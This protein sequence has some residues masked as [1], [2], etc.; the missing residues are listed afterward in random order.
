MTTFTLVRSALGPGWTPGVL[1][2]PRADGSFLTLA[3]LELPW[4]GNQRGVSCIPAGTYPVQY[5]WSD[6][7]NC[8]MPH[9]LD[10]PGRDAIEIHIGNG[11]GDTDG[12]IIVGM[13]ATALGVGPSRPAFERFNAWL[14]RASRDH[15]LLRIDNPPVGQ[16]A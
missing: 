7:W 15:V 11:P 9:V 6:R 2:C 3:T 4:R 13:A 10:V 8:L 5:G 1:S 14:G 12:C 16:V